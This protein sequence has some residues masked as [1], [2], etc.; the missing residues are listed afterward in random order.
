MK[1]MDKALILLV[2]IVTLLVYLYMQITNE[3]PLYV[4]I[5][6]DGKTIEKINLNEDRI[7]KT[8]YG[9]IINVKDGDVW[10]SWADCPDELCV[11]QGT[12]RRTGESIICIPNKTIV[13]ISD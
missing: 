6:Y 5:S 10:V 13:M 8:E 1:K 3:D 9:N 7:L 2:M 4:G 12:I 11:R